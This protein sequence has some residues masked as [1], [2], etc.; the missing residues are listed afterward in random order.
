[1]V[2]TWVSL[3]GRYS[4]SVYFQKRVVLP[5]FESPMMMNLKRFYSPNDRNL[6]SI[7]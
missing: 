7:V 4:P 5:T 2:V 3:M 6:S 1:M